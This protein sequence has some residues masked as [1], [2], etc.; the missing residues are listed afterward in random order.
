MTPTEKHA[1]ILQSCIN[2]LKKYVENRT[3]GAVISYIL[4]KYEKRIQKECY[5]SIEE[6]VR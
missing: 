5:P 4:E 2:E 3:D 6:L 1:E